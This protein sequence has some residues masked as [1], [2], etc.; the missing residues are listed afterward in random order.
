MTDL[1]NSICQPALPSHFNCTGCS[2]A[3]AERV[4]GSAA[5]THPLKINNDKT[6]TEKIP[7]AEMG[8][9]RSVNRPN[10]SFK[11]FIGNATVKYALVRRKIQTSGNYNSPSWRSA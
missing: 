7:P 3:L 11:Y 9:G 8:C 5:P 4:S 10:L 2:T 1:P 6:T